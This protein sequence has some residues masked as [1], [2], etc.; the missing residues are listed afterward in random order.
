VALAPLG[1]PPHGPHER[2]CGP[3]GPPPPPVAPSG[4]APA[5]PGN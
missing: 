5:P 2:D 3:G 4:A 1:R